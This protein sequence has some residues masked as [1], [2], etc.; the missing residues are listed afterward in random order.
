MF[1]QSYI[2]IF[3]NAFFFTCIYTSKK[4]KGFKI[5]AEIEDVGLM[6]IKKVQKQEMVIKYL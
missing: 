3:L 5:N 4:K 1:S 6:K 2:F